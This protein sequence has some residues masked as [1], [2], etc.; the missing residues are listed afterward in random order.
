MRFRKPKTS[1]RK[2]RKLGAFK[3]RSVDLKMRIINAESM[4]ELQK[5]H[6]RML[7]LK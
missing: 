3:D 7:G 5:V 2:Y 6:H 1:S 4:E